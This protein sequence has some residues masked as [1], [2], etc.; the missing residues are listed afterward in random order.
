MVTKNWNEIAPGKLLDDLDDPTFEGGSETT[1]EPLG[2]QDRLYVDQA[3]KAPRFCRHRDRVLI[4][5]VC[6]CRRSAEFEV[7]YRKAHWCCRLLEP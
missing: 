3:S 2:E 4:L 7:A 5:C 6:L 1:P